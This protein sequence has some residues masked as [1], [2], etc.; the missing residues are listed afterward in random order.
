MLTVNIQSVIV[1]MSQIFIILSGTFLCLE[2]RRGFGRGKLSGGFDGVDSSLLDP[3]SFLPMDA[4]RKLDYLDL[5][6]NRATRFANITE[7]IKETVYGTK[8]RSKENVSEKPFGLG[9]GPGFV[10][11]AGLGFGKPNF[12]SVAGIV[13]YSVYHRYVMYKNL[14]YKTRSSR[15]NYMVYMEADIRDYRKHYDK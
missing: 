6:M 1:K 2:G 9:V 5:E 10:G 13:T 7:R 12:G 3:T 4:M 14:M 11:S 15:N 8:I